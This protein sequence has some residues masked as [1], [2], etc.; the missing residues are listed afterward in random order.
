MSRWHTLTRLSW[1]DLGM[2]VLLAQVAEPQQN[3]SRG[4]EESARSRSTCLCHHQIW[5]S[6]RAPARNGKCLMITNVQKGPCHPLCRQACIARMPPFATL[7]TRKTMGGRRS[8]PILQAVLC[9]HAT[10]T[11]IGPSPLFGQYGGCPA[12]VLCAK[13]W[14]FLTL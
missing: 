13:V 1:L 2:G 14:S 4:N 6:H 7:S 3:G 5:R 11:M 8:T 12:L 10:G 9:R